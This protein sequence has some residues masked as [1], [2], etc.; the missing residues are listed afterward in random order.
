MLNIF[1][2]KYEK[3]DN[4]LENPEEIGRTLGE[5]RKNWK[6]PEKNRTIIEAN[7]YDPVTLKSIL[8][9]FIMKI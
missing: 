2:K 5:I 4:S 6:Y 8:P 7:S 1:F 9:S 3:F